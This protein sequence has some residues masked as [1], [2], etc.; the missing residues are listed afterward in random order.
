MKPEIHAGGFTEI[1]LSAQQEIHGGI[2]PFI[3]AVGIAMV[4]EII[5]D[6]DNFKNGLL[7]RPEEKN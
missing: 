3:A 5:T 4:T 2:L 1:P 6:W 7:G